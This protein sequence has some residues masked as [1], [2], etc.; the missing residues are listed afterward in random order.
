MQYQRLETEVIDGIGHIWLNRPD[1]RNAL[2]STMVRE[3]RQ[4]VEAMGEDENVRSIVVGGR[5]TAFC[6]GADLGYLKEISGYSVEENLRDSA[7]LALTLRT[8]YEV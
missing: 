7:S 2:D 5:G 4:A 6:A 1:K 3:L 8:I